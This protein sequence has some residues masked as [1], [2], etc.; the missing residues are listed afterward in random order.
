MLPDRLFSEPSTIFLC[1]RPILDNISQP[2]DSLKPDWNFHFVGKQPSLEGN[3]KRQ[4]QSK[5]DLR[6]EP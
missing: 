4:I 6:E 2:S 5:Q 1:R 3:W